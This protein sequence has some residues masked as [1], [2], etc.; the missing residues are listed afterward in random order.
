M[1]LEVRRLSAALT[2]VT[3]ESAAASVALEDRATERGGHPSAALARALG[4]VLELGARLGII[5][6]LGRVASGELSVRGRLCNRWRWRLGRGRVSCA[7]ARP[8]RGR[9]LLPLELRHQSAQ[10]AQAQLAQVDPW[11]CLRE[12]CFRLLDELDVLLARFE[13]HFV[14]LGFQ[15]RRRRRFGFRRHRVCVR[16]RQRG[17]DRRGVHIR[18]RQ[19]GTGRHSA[20]VLFQPRRARAV[21][22]NRRALSPFHPVARGALRPVA[23]SSPG[24]ARGRGSGRS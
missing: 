16:P 12:K 7:L 11:R 3:A 2:R 21:V 1:E 4:S 19:R 22:R 20:R 18:P 17:I 9:V 8:V 15:P 5:A 24:L 6:G 14:A 13:L 10:G 23:R